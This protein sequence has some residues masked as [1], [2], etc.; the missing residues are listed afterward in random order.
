METEHPVGGPFGS[1]FSAFVII[2]ELWRPGVAR[3]G[4]F[5]RTF[6]HFWKHDLSQ[7]VA[8][9][10]IAPKVYQGHTHICLTLFQV[11]SKSVRFRLSYC[12]TREDRFCPVEY[13][14]YRYFD[15]IIKSDCC[16]MCFSDWHAIRVCVIT[17]AAS[18]GKRNVT[19]WRPSVCLSVPSALYSVTQQGAACDAVCSK[20]DR[21]SCSYNSWQDFNWQCVARFLCKS[22]ASFRELPK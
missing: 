17:L 3:P 15:S 18:S 20:E 7:T 12:R 6:L 13:L 21:H 4:Y 22:W 16:R 11:T 9:A 10:R 1:E 5:V 8:T 14:Q 2:A 19:V